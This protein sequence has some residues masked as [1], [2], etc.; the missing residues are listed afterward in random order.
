MPNKE[1]FSYTSMKS[2]WNSFILK[3]T[4]YYNKEELIEEI[5]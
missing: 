1:G 2:V 4:D 3:L 5:E